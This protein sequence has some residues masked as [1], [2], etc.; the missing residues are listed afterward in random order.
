M[1][2]YGRTI[3]VMSS[4]AFYRAKIEKRMVAVTVL[5][6]T[7]LDRATFLRPANEWVTRRILRA[8]ESSNLGR[9]VIL[10]RPDWS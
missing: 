9:N 2:G 4:P 6:R 7:E 3:M 8:F 10:S 1:I 5:V